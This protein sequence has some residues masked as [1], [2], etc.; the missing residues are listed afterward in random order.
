MSRPRLYFSGTEET[1]TTATPFGR[2]KASRP[3]RSGACAGRSPGPAGR[4][5]ARP[6]RAT[7]RPSREM[8]N[9]FTSKDENTQRA[10]PAPGEYAA[11][12][13]LS[14]SMPR[15]IRSRH[16]GWPVCSNLCRMWSVRTNAYASS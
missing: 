5:S 15:A 1:P 7:N 8:A 10:G 2:K 13:L 4:N 3:L 9:G 12:R 16:S 14:R 11:A 6:S